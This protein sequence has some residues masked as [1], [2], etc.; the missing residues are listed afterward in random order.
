MMRRKKIEMNEKLKCI[1]EKM[2]VFEE[3]TFFLYY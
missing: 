2:K 3:H 1:V